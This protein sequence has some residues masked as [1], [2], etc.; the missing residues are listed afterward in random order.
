M[1][2]TVGVR[3]HRILEA[4]PGY[5]RHDGVGARPSG[6]GHAPGVLVGCYSNPPPDNRKVWVFEE[7]L[8]WE[9]DGVP[10]LVPFVRIERATLPDGKDS[11]TITLHMSGGD[12]LSVPVTGGEGQFR[13]AM[14]M[15]HF[16]HR[17]LGDLRLVPG[18]P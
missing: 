6:F 1:K 3:A 7:G 14:A 16:M 12:V 2:M 18:S 13:D 15:L 5:S 10:V 4:L 9:C 17:V 8:A 11:R